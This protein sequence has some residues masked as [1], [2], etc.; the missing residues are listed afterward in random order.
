METGI[1]QSMSEAC[2]RL[3]FEKV[4]AKHMVESEVEESRTAEIYDM[5]AAVSTMSRKS[6]RLAV[7]LTAGRVPKGTPGEDVRTTAEEV[8]DQRTDKSKY[9]QNSAETEGGKTY[10]TKK[11]QPKQGAEKM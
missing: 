11:T 4:M 1:P 8:K 10:Q 9:A 3:E 6:G 5:V 2:Q 7:Q